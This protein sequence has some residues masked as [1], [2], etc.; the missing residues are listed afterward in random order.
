MIGTAWLLLHLLRQSGASV[1]SYVAVVYDTVKPCSLSLSLKYRR[2]SITVQ[3]SV[4][5][6]AR[7]VF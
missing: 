5:C 6:R 4:Y 1:L 2:N 3:C 7:T